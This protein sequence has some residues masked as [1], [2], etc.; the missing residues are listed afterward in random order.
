MPDSF[1]KRKFSVIQT[2]LSCRRVGLIG[3]AHAMRAA[4]MPVTADSRLTHA[5]LSV[6][7]AETSENTAP[8]STAASWSLSP[9]RMMCA[10]GGTALTQL[11]REPGPASTPRRRR[12]DR[13]GSGFGVMAESPEPGSTPSRRWMNDSAG[14]RSRRRQVGG[15]IA[16][17]LQHP[18]GRL[19]GRGCHADAAVRI[20]GKDAGKHVDDGGRLAGAGAAADDRQAA[21]ERQGRRDLLPVGAIPQ[22][23]GVDGEQAVEEA[24]V[25][26]DGGRRGGEGVIRRSASRRS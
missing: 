8:D 6:G 24:C 12:G 15:G 9:S 2:T 18:G 19:A 20:S 25:A 4:G 23:L 3:A 14:K 16:D 21:F 5:L 22:P 26:A 17:R 11:G 1:A 10:A 13:F 7:S